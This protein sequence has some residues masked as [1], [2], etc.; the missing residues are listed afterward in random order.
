[1]HEIDDKILI[2]V[3][4]ALAALFGSLIPTV[5]NYFNNEKQRDFERKKEL[6]NRQ[7]DLYVE[8]ML[9]LQSIINGQSDSEF[10]KLQEAALKISTYGAC[11]PSQAFNKYYFELVRSGNQ[12]R[13]PLTQ[14]EHQE[15]QMDII[16]TMR[17]A[18]GLDSLEYFEVIA[19]RPISTT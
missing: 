1:M 11:K 10:I 8:V 16:N 12:S 3:I 2:A 14:K 6:Y 5:F 17:E 9:A 15:F 19:Y 7:K 13:I 4:A 18:M